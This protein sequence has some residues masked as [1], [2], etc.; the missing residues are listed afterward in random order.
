MKFLIEKPSIQDI[1]V[2]YFSKN[3]VDNLLS[4][5]I[6]MLLALSLGE[7]DHNN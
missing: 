7:I 4:V 1:L 3:T 6:D 2:C 5:D